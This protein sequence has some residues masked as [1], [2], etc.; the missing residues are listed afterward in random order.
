MRVTTSRYEISGKKSQNLTLQSIIYP[1]KKKPIG[2]SSTLVKVVCCLSPFLHAKLITFQ[3]IQ[4]GDT[5]PT[6]MTDDRQ[7]QDKRAE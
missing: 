1:P 4:V 7:L 2:T 3:C 5:D 6:G